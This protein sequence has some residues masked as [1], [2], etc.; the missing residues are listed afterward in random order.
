MNL[1]TLEPLIEP[2]DTRKRRSR[3]SSS[4][5]PGPSNGNDGGNGNDDNGRG[6][7]HSEPEPAYEPGADKAKVIT[8]FLLI[9]VGMTFSGLIGAYIMIS[10][11]RA[12][13]WKPFYL[14]VQ[15]WISTILIIISSFSYHLAK[16]SIYAGDLASARRWLVV[17]TGL[18][19]AFISSQIL[20]WLALSN[21]GLYMYGNPY[22]GF[23]YILTAV[24]LVHVV[25]GIA[26]LGTVVLR[27]WN[28]TA[29]TDEVKSRHFVR[30]VGWYW[31]FMGGL[32]IVLFV[33]LGFWR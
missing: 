18:G 7:P 23:F 5:G 9:V 30:A 15:V 28:G 19:A 17:T 4:G 27:T 20:A 13:E 3:M 24:H 21:R 29:A 33:L 6:C 8:G 32:W 10:T 16:R 22:A 26:A 25:G 2:E 1:G 31:D 14:P 11:N 12:A